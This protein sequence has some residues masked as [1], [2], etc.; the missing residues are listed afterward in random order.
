MFDHIDKTRG[1][2]DHWLIQIA[3]AVVCLSLLWL[4]LA[5]LVLW[6]SSTPVPERFRFPEL[7]EAEKHWINTRYTHH[8][9]KIRPYRTPEG[10]FFDRDGKRCKL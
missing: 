3:K 4:Y 8:G 7:T 9:D 5:G 1:E 6:I 10:F 2:T